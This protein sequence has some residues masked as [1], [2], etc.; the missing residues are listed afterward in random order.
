MVKN[1]LLYSRGTPHEDIHHFLFYLMLRNKY[2]RH[3]MSESDL[4]GFLPFSQPARTK[5]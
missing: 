1:K 5:F 4:E 2:A 3:D